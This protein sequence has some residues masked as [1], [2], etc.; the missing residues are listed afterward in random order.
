MDHV[1]NGEVHERNEYD[2]D[3][4]QLEAVQ[5]QATSLP[6]AEEYPGVRRKTNRYIIN[7]LRYFVN[8]LVSVTQMVYGSKDRAYCRCRARVA[9]H[10][11]HRT[12]C[13][14]SDMV[15]ALS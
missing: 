3:T 10:R 12:C 15:A 7:H 8:Q 14:V 13:S 6:F 11:S 1:R 5:E 2:H 9:L 4:C